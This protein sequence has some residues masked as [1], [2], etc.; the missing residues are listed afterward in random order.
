L[1]SSKKL[2]LKTPWFG[3]GDEEV[4]QFLHVEVA[5]VVAV[6]QTEDSAGH[7]SAC[8]DLQNKWTFQK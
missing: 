2:Q 7:I 1:Y 3:N 5:V 4:H 6:G 8:H